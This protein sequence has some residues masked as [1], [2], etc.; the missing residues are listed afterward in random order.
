M[1]ICLLT[2][3]GV[4]AEDLSRV[5]EEVVV[6]ATKKNTMLQDTPI[7]V[8][9][10]GPGMLEKAALTEVSDLASA[11]PNLSMG[12]EGFTNSLEISMRGISSNSNTETSN[13]AVSVNL[14]GVYI[15][16]PQGANALF[17]D[18]ERV[19]VLRGPQGTLFGRNS[20][21]GAINVVSHKPTDQLEGSIKFEAGNYDQ[22]AVRGV[23]N[24]PV[25]ETFALRASLQTEE[26]D[27]YFDN[28]SSPVPISEDYG[29]A[30]QLS[31][32]LS[33][34]YT[35]TDDFSW[36]LVYEVSQNDGA[37]TL[38]V[39]NPIP[40][41]E[42]VFDR[43]VSFAGEMDITFSTLRSRMDW[44]ISD[45]LRVT[46]V[47]GF[48]GLDRLQLSDADGGTGPGNEN[49]R[50]VSENEFFSH[51]VQL[52]TTGDG[53]LQWTVGAFY[54]E[55]KND[56]IFDAQQVDADFLVAFRNFDRGQ[57]ATALY[58]QGT[59]SVSDA[60]RVTAGARYTEDSKLDPDASAYFCGAPFQGSGFGSVEITSINTDDCNLRS[61]TSRE[62]DFN[63][64]T[65]R[66]GLDMD[67]N[68][69]VL[70]YGSVATGYKSGG[71]SNVAPAF[72]EE[73]VLTVEAGL[74]GNFLDN[75][76]RLNAALFSSSYED[77]Q[78]AQIVDNASRTENAAE[79]TING[80][81]LEGL[82]LVGDNTQIDGFVSWL[83][84]EFDE[85]MDACDA[86]NPPCS[87][88]AAN[89]LDLSGNKLTRSPEWSFNLGIE[90]NFVLAGGTLTPRLSVHWE[91]D[92]YVRVYNRDDIDKVDSWTK[93]DFTLGYKPHEGGWGLQFFAKNIEDEARRQSA[94][95]SPFG[96]VRGSF[97]NPRTYGVK[98][99]YRWGE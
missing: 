8:T 11:V 94:L 50:A 36:L 71:F 46:Y 31:G 68:D 76:L 93:T 82:W 41:G 38:S 57:E 12:M 62:E 72:D 75:T 59:Y 24:I 47:A 34:L 61:S 66:L 22:R 55:E 29:N 91:D 44:D 21:A 30:D 83:D 70:L 35:P 74:K 88:P 43:A 97:S 64:V 10:F 19:E 79:A 4:Q 73:T 13:P 80:L 2:A 32:R 53:A 84:A 49:L 54:F 42:D 77:M 60:V 45:Q 56:V 3:A 16:R 17:Y 37:G 67:M 89:L 7:A 99:D 98:F 90:H 33:A 27:G 6:T 23:L 9:A 52:Q 20:T 51:D 92:S 15:P 85:Y 18:V 14:D 25:S 96:A 86:T 58:G 5:L 48:G 78:L 28:S 26:R 81:E 1:A 39:P 65:W 87:G 40:A 69:D 63:A 95:V